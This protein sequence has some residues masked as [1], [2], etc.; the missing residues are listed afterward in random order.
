MNILA[1]WTPG[2]LE[3]VMIFL[4]SLFV[5]ILPVVAF[6][7]ISSK[8]GFPAALGLLMIV[9]VANVILPLYLAFAEWP[10]LSRD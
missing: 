5:W 7:R 8:A 2:P 9:P 10:A 1:L 6:C 4:V 3:I